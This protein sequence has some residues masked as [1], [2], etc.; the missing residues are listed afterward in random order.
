[1]EGTAVRCDV[2]DCQRDRMR[3]ARFC[4]SHINDVWG[5]RPVVAE[6][7]RLALEQT[8]RRGYVAVKSL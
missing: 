5:N 1:M 3:D 8:K 7:R 4:K 2:T 6:W